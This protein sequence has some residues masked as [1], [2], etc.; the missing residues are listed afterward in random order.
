MYNALFI[1]LLAIAA[2][3]F[4]TGAKRQIKVRMFTGAL[5]AALTILFFWFMDFWGEALWY[6]SLG[7]GDRFWIINTS[8][9]GFGIAGAVLGYL[10]VYLLMLPIPKRNKVVHR[11]AG[12]LG[13]VMGGLWGY[14]NWEVILKF[15]NRVDTGMRDPILGKDV[16]FY[17]FSLPFYDSLYWLLVLTSAIALIAALVVSFTRFRENNIFLYFPYEFEMNSTEWSSPV[18]LTASVF[19]F[20][21]ALGRFLE[22]YHLMFSTTGVVAGPGWTDVNILLPAY[23][24]VIALLIVIGI[25]LLVPYTR[26]KAGEF[27][28]RK[29]RLFPDRPYIG[30]LAFPAVII[31]AIWIIAFAA[32][33][34]VFQWLVVEPNEITFE[35]PYIQNNIKYTRTAFGLDRIEEKEYPLTGTFTQETVADNPNIFN[36]VRLWD[37]KALD[38]VYRQFQS[39]RLYYEFSDVDVDRYNIDG[40][41][42][43]V[44]VSGR[45]INLDNLPPQSQ[46]FVNQRFQYTHGYGITMAAVNEFTEQGLPHLLIKDIPPVSESPSLA[47][48][49]PQIYFG[50][51]TKSPVVVNTK[52][53]EFDYPSGEDNVYTKYAGKG[54]V[55]LSN[56]WR[57]FLYGWKFDGTNFL[58]SDYPT[59]QSRIMFHRQVQERVKLLA[60]FLNFDKDAYLVLANGRLYWMLDAYT[61]S[62]NYPYSQPFSSRE[63]IPYKE[64]NETKNLTTDFSDYLD[65]I[66][67]IRNSVKA[68]VDAY[69]GTVNFYIMDKKDPIITVWSRIFPRLFKA[70]EEMPKELLSHLRYPMEM[71]LTQGIVY[72]KYHMMDPTVFYNQE[73]LWVRAT[74]KY[75]NEVQPV[76]PYYI[77]WQV[78]GTNKQQF[79]LMLPF[80]PKNRQ[81]LIGW[82]AGMCDPENYGRFISYQ[83]PKDQ[84]VLGP[85]QVE[86]KIDQDSYLSGQLTLWDQHGSKVIRGNV[87]AIPVNNTL[88]YVEPIYLQAETAAYP[89]L[90]L[91]VVMHQENM[92]YAK[93][94]EEALS[95]LFSRGPV[96][97]EKQAAST[98]VKPPLSQQAP[99]PVGVQIKA[100]NDAF[101]NYLRLLGEK[102]FPEAA[103]ELEKLQ[104]SLQS[105]SNQAK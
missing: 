83:F 29:F 23:A 38:A 30:V 87:L 88:F 15:W 34:Q 89:E 104:Q 93:T 9:I 99:P 37:W 96:V 33:P 79:V 75:Y 18:F 97:V 49:R 31:I 7:Y 4:F 73:D 84:T 24:V 20:V 103:R 56:F 2:F 27:Y 69:D 74:A 51:D 52:A 72:S 11:L 46:T 100:A 39:I 28:S 16:G 21:L 94:F 62:G 70:K 54:G 42:R 19:V 5:L 64:G 35:R 85:Q 48:K 53:K 78:P 82:I 10:L 22:R 81:V 77:M 58:F 68:V 43:Q 1:I 13:L 91:V 90:R 80:T 6:E 61:T 95:G 40:K 92:S 26:R 67:Y 8:N 71:L 102:K 3:L 98:S 57:K 32:L 101:N 25:L 41:V 44:M 45:E 12:L 50:E 55:E 86:T 36:N 59:S 47:V 76:D 66:N 17:L 63:N 60:P 14:S 105:L 65:G